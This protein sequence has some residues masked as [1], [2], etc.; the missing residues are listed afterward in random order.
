MPLTQILSALVVRDL[1]GVMREI[2]AFPDDASVWELRPGVTNSAGTLALHLVG[3][4]NHYIGHYLGQTGYVRDRPREFSTTGVS[5]AE[6]V[7]MLAATREMIATV[8]PRVTEEQLDLPYPESHSGRTI[9]TRP[10]L[11]HV[12]THLAFHLGQIGYLRRIVTG[13][14]HSVGPLSALVLPEA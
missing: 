13:Q 2:E 7:A 4:L 1:G 6:L 3:N 12:A 14:N 5:R 11:V 8:L 10:F 9:A